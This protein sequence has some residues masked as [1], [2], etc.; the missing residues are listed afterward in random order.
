[1][2]PKVSLAPVAPVV[3][4]VLAL[5]ALANPA[6][7]AAG[8][9]A[10]AG[11]GSECD[12]MLLVPAGTLMMGC[13][14]AA[15]A[16]CP[17]DELPLHAV[18]VPAFDIDQYEATVARYR[19]CVEAG[20]CSV[21]GI[22]SV[23]PAGSPSC[24]WDV[25]GRDQHPQNCITW[26]QAKAFCEWAGRRLCS[27]AEWERAARGD[28]GRL[29]PWGDQPPTCEVAVIDDGGMGCGTNSTMPVGSKPEGAGP[30]GALDLAGNVGEWVQDGWHPDYT[31]APADGRAWWDPTFPG[32]VV[33]GGGF[34]DSGAPDLGASKRAQY[35]P[36]SDL[37]M[38]G[39]RCCTGLL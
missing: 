17:Q 16:A 21:P 32:R 24:N 34:G 22:G 23:G 36:S 37:V 19:A 10:T 4:A 26:D 25:P 35:T 12:R 13:D 14:N 7:D 3:L 28:D 38:V 1:M 20:P 30:F 8:A 9:S 6:C 5:V 29:F 31:G 18:D 27:E 2:T 39:V 11:C 15:G 33:R